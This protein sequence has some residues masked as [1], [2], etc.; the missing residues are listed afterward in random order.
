MIATRLAALLVCAGITT[1]TAP[2]ALAMP[3]C[4]KTCRRETAGC[5]RTRC[6][7]LRGQARQDC[8]ETCEG[9]GGCGRVGTLAY[10]VSTCTERAFRQRLQIRHGDCDPVT[11]LDF[12]EPLETPHPC[13]VIGDARIG[14][15][16]SVI[17]GAFH[18]MGVS[19]DGRH[20]VFEVTDDFTNFQT[21]H[22]VPPE[23]QEGIFIV[24]ADGRDR[25]RR[26]GPAS[27]APSFRY[28]LDAA[29]PLGVRASGAEGLCFSPDG[30]EVVL[31]D[32]GPGPGG[33]EAVQIFTLDLVTGHGK[34][35]THLPLVADHAVGS[36]VLVP[37]TGYPC[38]I[39]DGRITFQS[40]G[41]LDGSNPEGS[42][43][44]WLIKPDGSD[45]KRVALP[46]AAAGSQVVP[47]F[48]IAGTSV[49]KSA[50][51]LSVA[52]T[53]VNPTGFG[54]PIS[55]IF[56]VDRSNVLQLT[57][58]ERV[59]TQFAALTPGGQRAI[60]V[61]SANP[62]NKNPSGTCQVF[63][64]DTAGEGLRQLTHFSQP[65]YSVNG[66]NAFVPPGCFIIP[67]GVDS[68]TGTLVFYSSCDAFGTNPYGDQLFGIRKDGTHLGQLTHARG[69][70]T[71]ADGTVSA[72]N[73]GPVAYS[74][75]FSNPP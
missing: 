17:F 68:V 41:N 59:D 19:L 5:E 55:E 60:F 65:E 2:L 20:V 9:I 21:K 46:V 23:Q 37:G 63:S 38:F 7:T 42:V 34:Q 50:E 61:A 58:F 12:P 47:I 48:G 15:A 53:P 69:E 45:L 10:V 6:A 22:L 11:L 64:I 8:L 27:R 39:P 16:T 56:L 73:I 14:L 30:R 33:E 72:E 75:S 32:L 36:S 57:K 54:D 62:L 44:E 1:L 35:L 52:G 25:P 49:R 67:L 4:T 3:H 29:A 13:K 28:G 31:T 51:A 70:V 43:V 24:R 18:R 71:G 66:C 26:L 74:A 40:F